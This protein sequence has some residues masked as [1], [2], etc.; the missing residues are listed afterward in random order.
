MRRP[1]ALTRD[2]STLIFNSLLILLLVAFL[3]LV[4]SRANAKEVSL[5]DLEASYAKA[6]L[7]EQMVRGDERDIVQFLGIDPASYEDALYYRGTEALSVD[8]F[9]VVKTRSKDDLPPIQDAVEERISSQTTAF[10]GYGPEQV[11][12]L[13]NAIVIKRGS[14]L[15]YCVAEDPEAYEEVFKDAI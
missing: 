9:L 5:T 2:R 10:E 1:P 11:K 7:T 6:G 15:F 4:Y 13:G 14:Y 8:E 12:R 3:A